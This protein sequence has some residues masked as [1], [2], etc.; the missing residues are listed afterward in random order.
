LTVWTSPLARARKTCRLAGYAE[1]AQVDADL[2]EWDY[3]VYEGHITD[4]IRREISE[5][6]V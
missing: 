1:S 2:R 4:D 6:S 3:G 5:W